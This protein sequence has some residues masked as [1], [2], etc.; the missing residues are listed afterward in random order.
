M[1]KEDLLSRARAVELARLL[2]KRNRKNI[3]GLGKQVLCL[4]GELIEELGSPDPAVP[5]DESRLGILQLEA[6]MIVR[7]GGPPHDP[8]RFRARAG[9]HPAA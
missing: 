3:V 6:P 2:K 9:A 8:D 7:S 1:K 4:G 5:P